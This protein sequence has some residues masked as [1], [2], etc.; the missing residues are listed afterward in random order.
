MPGA[1]PAAPPRKSLASH[2]P[3]HAA[4]RPRT[5]KA[6]AVWQPR[7]APPR[8]E[9]SPVSRTPHAAHPSP[10]RPRRKKRLGQPPCRAHRLPRRREKVWPATRRAMP[11]ADRG[12]P[13]RAPYGSHAAPRPATKIVLLVAHRTPRTHR[14]AGRAA[15]KS[16]AKHPTGCTPS[17]NTRPRPYG[18]GARFPFVRFVPSSSMSRSAQSQEPRRTIAKTTARG[19]PPVTSL[20]KVLSATRRATPPRLPRRREKVWPAT[21][22]AM[23]QADRGPPKRAP[24]GSHTAPRPAAKIVL[25]VAR[26]A[27]SPCLPRRKK[28]LGQPPC[29]AHRPSPAV[30]TI[31][32]QCPSP[33]ARAPARTGGGAFPVCPFRSF[34]QQEPQRTIAKASAARSPKQQRDTAWAAAPRAW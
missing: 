2:T 17:Q 12:P 15:A 32:Q 4:G 6:R 20:R 23:P 22:R 31:R 24:Y 8:H 25:L 1:P 34:L 21:R 28:R 18:R 30:K 7:R 29:R 33:K 14:P 5:A 11:Q 16:P 3:R 19:R 13:K 9:N 26:R 27:P 10:R